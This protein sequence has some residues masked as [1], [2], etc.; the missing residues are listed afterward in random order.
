MIDEPVVWMDSH[1]DYLVN[2]KSLSK[3]MVN[4][5]KMLKGERP[6]RPAPIYTLHWVCGDESGNLYAAKQYTGTALLQFAL[7]AVDYYGL[8]SQAPG[9]RYY[10]GGPMEFT[11]D[12]ID[13]IGEQLNLLIATGKFS[14][15]EM[16]D[17]I[18][19]NHF[20]IC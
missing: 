17:G 20:L 1:G 13:A 5:R 7:Y 4:R 14:W 18:V 3:L 8:I 15:R 19:P 9:Q 12:D 10:A 16:P 2:P 6:V 11:Q